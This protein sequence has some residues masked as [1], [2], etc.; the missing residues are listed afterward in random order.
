M[1]AS[2]TIVLFAALFFA[3]ASCNSADV[4]R[5][6]IVA[7]APRNTNFQQL[8]VGP[9]RDV[10]TVDYQFGTIDR[11][12]PTG[13]RETFSLGTSSPVGIALGSDGNFRINAAGAHDQLIRV[14][15]SGGIAQI[16]I[17]DGQAACGGS[18]AGPG[19]KVWFTQQFESATSPAI[20]ECS[21]CWAGVRD[22]PQAEPRSWPSRLGATAELQR[23]DDDAEAAIALERFG[24]RFAAR[25]EPSDRCRRR[26]AKRGRGLQFIRCSQRDDMV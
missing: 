24:I 5:W 21:N 14:T 8:A 26:D 3:M 9:D 10:W 6:S 7:T 16:R 25:H 13:G 2:G 19:A 22:E 12:T 1:R 17:P 18:V 23:L 20:A 11:C 15:A 4:G